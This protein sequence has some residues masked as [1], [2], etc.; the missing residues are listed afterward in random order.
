MASPPMIA[1]RV[2]V[3]TPTWYSPTGLR[4]YIV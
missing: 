4:L 2:F 1:H 3:Q